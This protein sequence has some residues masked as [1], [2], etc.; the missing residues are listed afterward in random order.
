MDFE[1]VEEDNSVTIR[2]RDTM[3]QIRVNSDNLIEAIHDQ[4]K[5]FS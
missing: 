3:K 5:S 4:L 2:H 1:S